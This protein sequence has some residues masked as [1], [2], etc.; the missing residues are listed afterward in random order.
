VDGLTL[1]WKR[2]VT[3]QTVDFMRHEVA[4]VRKYSDKRRRQFMCIY[5][6]DGLDYW[7]FGTS[8]DVF[9]W[10]LYD[11]ARRLKRLA[12]A[13]RTS[14]SRMSHGRFWASRGC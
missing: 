10:D 9:S 3:H 6:Y 13:A 7:K 14:F 4:A 11:V 2:F 8:S 5:P 12:M 1:D